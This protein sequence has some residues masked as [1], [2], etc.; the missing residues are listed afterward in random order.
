M[1][2][3]ELW[4]TQAADILPTLAK[5]GDLKQAVV[6]LIN[7]ERILEPQ[8]ETPGRVAQFRKLL[9]QFVQGRGSES[10]IAGLLEM[11]LPAT[12]SVYGSYRDVF[13]TDWGARLLQRQALRFYNQAVLMSLLRRQQPSVRIAGTRV[14][15]SARDL[16]QE[17]TD[18]F[19]RGL[20]VESCLADLVP[21]V[22]MPA[23]TSSVIALPVQSAESQPAFF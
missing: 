18:V 13:A 15:H 2:N 19:S 22:V 8:L 9:V 6:Q 23:S 11:R 21:A 16:L 1:P 4:A 10:Q 5:R 3:D 7:S 12:E 20:G 14:I 17:L